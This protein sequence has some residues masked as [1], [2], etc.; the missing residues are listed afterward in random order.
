MFLTDG[1]LR[2]RLTTR[3]LRLLGPLQILDWFGL[4]RIFRLS[5]KLATFGSVASM[6]VPS[7]VHVRRQGLGLCS[8]MHHRP[9]AVQR[10]KQRAVETIA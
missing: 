7:A 10:I 3:T 4:V 1:E 2:W 8:A 5:R 9:A 6:R